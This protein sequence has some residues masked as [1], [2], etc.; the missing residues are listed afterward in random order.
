MHIFMLLHKQLYLTQPCHNKKWS[1]H[2]VHSANLSDK[3]TCMCM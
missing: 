2:L 1:V 3:D